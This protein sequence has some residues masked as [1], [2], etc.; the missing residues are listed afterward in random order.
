[1]GLCTDTSPALSIIES[2]LS[3][4]CAAMASVMLAWSFFWISAGVMVVLATVLFGPSFC[5]GI[6]VVV[7]LGGGVSAAARPSIILEE[8]VSAAPPA[9]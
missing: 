8:V 4:F 1:M 3:C 6:G 5:G 9:A 7:A 2:R